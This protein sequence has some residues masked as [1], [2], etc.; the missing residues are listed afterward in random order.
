MKALTVRQPFA[1]RLVQGTKRIENRSWSTPV[2]GRLVIHAGATPHELFA[3]HRMEHLPFRALI[4]TV[5]L[6]GVHSSETC[7]DRCVDVGGFPTGLHTTPGTP[8]FHWE[9][10]DPMPFDDGDLV[11]ASGALGLWDIGTRLGPS[12]EHL[13]T[14]AAAAARP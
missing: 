12:A 14:I 10:T 6:T 5:Q 8:W 13:A 9:V 4:G 2:R 3:R 11:P 1:S 7:G